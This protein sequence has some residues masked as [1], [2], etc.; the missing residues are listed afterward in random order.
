[1][2]HRFKND[3]FCFTRKEKTCGTFGTTMYREIQFAEHLQM[4]NNNFS[5]EKHIIKEEVL[6]NNNITDE[7]NDCKNELFSW[8]I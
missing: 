1:M 7:R 2:P 8:R 4:W 5:Q 6:I 3:V